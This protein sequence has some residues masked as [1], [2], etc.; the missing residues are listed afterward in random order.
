[1]LVNVI[2]KFGNKEIL[3]NV[4]FEFNN[5]TALVGLNVVG[6]TTLIKILLGLEDVQSGEVKFDVKDVSVCLSEN[7]LP[8]YLTINE[9]ANV[10]QFN[11]ENLHNLLV[12]FSI[13]EYK[14]TL[15]KNLSL[16]TSKKMNLIVA[17]LTKRKYLILDEPTNGLDYQS[18]QYLK[19]ILSKD[20]R[21]LLLISHDF[22]FFE[23]FIDNIAILKNKQIVEHESIKNLILKKQ[24]NSLEEVLNEYLDK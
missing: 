11:K 2:K 8:E 6:K 23:K 18:L 10:F 4:S 17:L 7:I 9:I 16:G 5:K 24:K 20:K 1:M 12:N 14:N 19:T 3:N 21:E 13:L 22:S 15:I